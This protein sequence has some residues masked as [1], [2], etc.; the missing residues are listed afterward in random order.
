MQQGHHPSRV[1]DRIAVICTT[2]PGSQPSQVPALGGILP[3]PL[4][5]ATEIDPCVVCLAAESVPVDAVEQSEQ[6]GA[7]CAPECNDEDALLLCEGLARRRLGRHAHGRRGRGRSAGASA[8]KE[9]A[10]RNSKK[11]PVME[12]LGSLTN[13]LF[14]CEFSLCWQQET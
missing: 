10:Q 5:E 12:L 8:C 4:Q 13:S 6:V 3:T 7:S 14:L 9:N 11:V 1:T 2:P